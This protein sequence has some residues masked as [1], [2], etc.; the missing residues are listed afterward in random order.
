MI[1]YWSEICALTLAGSL[2]TASSLVLFPES[3]RIVFAI[4]GA[5]G[6]VVGCW[7]GLKTVS[8]NKDHSEQFIS[9]FEY[10]K[11]FLMHLRLLIIVVILASVVGMMLGICMY[12][13]VGQSD[14]AS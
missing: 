11:L 4:A 8:A 7:L 2:A 1:L 14:S 6:G 10:Q 13:I 12:Y 3:S 5:V 9:N